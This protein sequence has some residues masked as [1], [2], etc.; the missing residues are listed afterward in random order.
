M[1]RECAHHLKTD[2]SYV[3]ASQLGELLLGM[4][5]QA[6]QGN[7]PTRDEFKKVESLLQQVRTTYNP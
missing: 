6:I 2:A 5:R 3:G 4:E 7:I 1:V